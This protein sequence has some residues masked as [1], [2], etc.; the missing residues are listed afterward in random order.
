MDG[1][2]MKEEDGLWTGNLQWNIIEE[3]EERED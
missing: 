1:G 2:G 3:K